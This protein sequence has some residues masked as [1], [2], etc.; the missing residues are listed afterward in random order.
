MDQSELSAWNDLCDKWQNLGYAGLTEPERMWL[1][2][3]RLIDSTNNGGI[4]S[5][6]YNDGADHLEDCMKA[7]RE[8]DT[9]DV[10]LAIER[11]NSL[12]SKGVPKSQQERNE[13]ISA[14]PKDETLNSFLELTDDQLADSLDD[15]EEKLD[16]FL[17]RS[18]LID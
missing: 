12:F 4:I 13:I 7:V 5:Y 15:L 14:W 11:I 18:K 17:R 1:N 8:L 2:I 3:R 9:S 6:Y 10:L 16:R